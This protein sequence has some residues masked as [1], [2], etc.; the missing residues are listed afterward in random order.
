MSDPHTDTAA[1]TFCPPDRRRYVLIAAILASSMGFIDGSVVAIAIPAIRADLGASLA[2]AQWV[3]NA[4]LL[5]LSGLL[6]VGGAAGD[7]FGLRNVF[8]GGI[9]LFVVASL[10]CALVPDAAL[11][12]AARTVQGLAAAVMVPASL[13]IIARAYPRDERG[14]AIGIWAAASSLTTVLGPVVGGGVLTLFGDWSWRLIFALNLPLGGLAVAL[15][16]LVP[17]D[18]P[19]AGQRLDLVGGGLATVGL[20][21]VAV[22]LTVEARLSVAIGTVGA[23]LVAL[24]LFVLWEGRTRAPMMPLGLFRSVRFS[25]A[26]ALTFALYF[27]LSAVSFYLPMTL[28]AGWGATAADVALVMVPL[29]VGLTLL[30]PVAGRLADR[31][32]AGPMIAAG[33][34]VVAL[35]FALLGATLSLRE[36]WFVVLPIMALFGAG[37]G[38]V[39]SPLSTAVM[40]SVEDSD[41]GIA[42][43]VNNAVARVAGLVAI[44]AMGIVVRVVF[45][46]ALGPFAE[47]QVFFGVA[48]AEALPPDAEAARL[49]AT[50][51]AFA[52]VA[53]VTA[54]LAAVSGVIAWFSQARRWPATR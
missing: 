10:A 38:L 4:Y 16:L 11:L 51:A 8:M 53:Y 30:S 31:V 17:A 19:R 52:A 48:P 22:G 14:R 43:G 39:V 40:T 13:A 28:I 36:L 37:M 23:G 2:A 12:I 20:L 47:L 35:A 25:G 50:D 33:S 26:Q 15:L 41:T 9:G 29:G 49:N 27:A 42:S 21:L 34:L 44:A 45:E 32:G 7:R 5:M 18:R 3:Q 1:E 6:L 54:G 24:A 46:R